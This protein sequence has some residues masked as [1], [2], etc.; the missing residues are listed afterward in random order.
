MCI[1]FNLK[2]NKKKLIDFFFRSYN[3][4]DCI[5][6]RYRKD[7]GRNIIYESLWLFESNEID[8]ETVDQTM[9]I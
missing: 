6:T 7:V 4:C 2:K 1:V 8:R 5:V 3:Y 9:E